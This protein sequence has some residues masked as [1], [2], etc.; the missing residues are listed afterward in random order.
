[1]ILIESVTKL[2]FSVPLSMTC[3]VPDIRRMTRRLPILA[4][5]VMVCLGFVRPAD[6]RLNGASPA[7]QTKR[8]PPQ[9]RNVGQGG[10]GGQELFAIVLEVSTRALGPGT[11]RGDALARR[12]RR[13]FR[14]TGW[15][16]NSAWFLTCAPKP[17]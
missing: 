13:R 14:D 1:M 9:Q 5:T 4:L 2:S 6:A 3:A 16:T 12:R 7:R 8:Q 17:P 15:T 11:R 10:P